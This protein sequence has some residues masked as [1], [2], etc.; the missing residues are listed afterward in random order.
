M[1]RGLKPDRKGE[2]DDATG[3]TPFGWWQSFRSRQQ[4]IRPHLGTMSAHYGL[5]LRPVAQARSA[6]TDARYV[7]DKIGRRSAA[8]EGKRPN[9][10]LQ[11][12]PPKPKEL[13]SACV[14]GRGVLRVR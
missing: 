6:D 13:L 10:R 8:H 3:A 9:S 4:R 11:L 2:P 7:G 14:M 5:G 1:L 12:V